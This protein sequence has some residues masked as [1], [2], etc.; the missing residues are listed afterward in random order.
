MPVLD[1]DFLIALQQQDPDAQR[2]LDSIQHET[3]YVPSI[4]VVEFMTG[5]EDQAGALEAIASSF[6][7]ADTDVA[8]ALELAKQRRRLRKTGAKIRVADFWIAGW[9]WLHDTVV[10]TR[11]EADYRPLGVTVLGY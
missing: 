2:L 8:W 11:N 5:F 6:T 9:A 10:V 4:V 3:L 7:I 1:T